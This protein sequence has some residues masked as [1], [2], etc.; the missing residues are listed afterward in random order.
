[1]TFKFFACMLNL[2]SNFDYTKW[3]CAL[4]ADESIEEIGHMAMQYRLESDA[5]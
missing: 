1:M 2:E 5:D 3:Q 4:C